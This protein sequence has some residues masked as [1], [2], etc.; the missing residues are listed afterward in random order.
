MINLLHP[1]VPETVRAWADEFAEALAQDVG[2]EWVD[3]LKIRI[4]QQALE[5]LAGLEDLT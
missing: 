5:L 3:E 1:I 2:E 4:H